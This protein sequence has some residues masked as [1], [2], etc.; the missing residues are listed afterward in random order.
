MVAL[1]VTVVILIGFP[2]AVLIRQLAVRDI[3]L[4]LERDAA[5]AGL[6]V[7]VEGV[8]GTDPIEL[9]QPSS[10][11]SVAVYDIAGNR[12][13]GTGPDTADPAVSGGLAATQTQTQT[14]GQPVVAVPLTFDEQLYGAIRTE[15][16]AGAVASRA[17]PYWLLLAGLAIGSIALSVL[18]ANLLGKRLARPIDQLTA[19]TIDVGAGSFEVDLDPTGITEI[20]AAAGALHDTAHQL[21]DVIGRERA[22]SS[23]VSHQL[24]TPLAGLQIDIEQATMP[25]DQRAAALTHI[26]RLGTTIDDLLRLR[27]HTRRAVT[28][29]P[30]IEALDQAEQRW[31]AA[32]AD[33]GRPLRTQ[34]DDGIETVPISE[35]ALRQ[36]L[37]VLIQNALDH[38]SGEVDITA[39]EIPGGVAVE[40][41][42]EGTNQSDLSTSED[43]PSTGIGLSLARSLA[44]AEGARLLGQATA[45][46][47]VY[48][49][50]IAT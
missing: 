30:L 38:G 31:H 42:D 13:A 40:V 7:S 8:A 32:L 11:V 50:I 22:F 37:D 24:R 5:S 49:L 43:P 15:A 10:G 17:L 1:V 46:E 35:P 34:V 12:V 26:Q 25:E 44:E 2:M 23:Q 28:V 20:D 39:R 6:A 16:P 18:L 14:D 29:T 19:A 3:Y 47:T 9:P 27:R 45:E 48:R 4:E 21:G 41:T 36:I 33:R